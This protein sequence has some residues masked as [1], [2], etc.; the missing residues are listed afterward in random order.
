MP[1]LIPSFGALKK[2]GL[3]LAVG[4]FALPAAAQTYTMKMASATK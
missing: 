1:G 2:L 4:A 3:A